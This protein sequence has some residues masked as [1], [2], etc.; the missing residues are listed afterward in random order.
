M[1][2]IVTRILLAHEDGGEI[3]YLY[4]REAFNLLNIE[5]HK[6]SKAQFIEIG[7]V[8][9]YGDRKFKV[10]SLNLKF[11]PEM[12]NMDPNIGINVFSPTDPSDFNCQVAVFVEEL[13]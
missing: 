2:S 6:P 12:Y 9:E 10:K 11:E 7:Q 8:V 13:D 3:A 4:N 5:V 1:E